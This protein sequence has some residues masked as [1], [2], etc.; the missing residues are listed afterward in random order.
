MVNCPITM[1]NHPFWQ[2][3]QLYNKWAIFNSF[4]YVITRGYPW[5]FSP[6]VPYKA[7]FC[8]DIHLH[9]PYIGLIDGRYLHFR[10]LKFPL[11][12]STICN[13]LGPVRLGV[14]GSLHLFP[15]PEPRQPHL[16]PFLA[17]AGD[18]GRVQDRVR[19]GL[20]VLWVGNGCAVGWN[21]VFW[22]FWCFLFLLF[23]RGFPFFLFDMFCSMLFLS[24]LVILVFDGR[25]GRVSHP[26]LRNGPKWIEID[27]R[28]ARKKYFT[29]TS[30]H[31][32]PSN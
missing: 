12:R 24:C 19:R 2:V 9:W 4:L 18:S 14:A 21:C 15:F 22:W 13:P 20:E 30:H 16:T 3:N 25:F 28:F 17:A 10:I 8:G 26:E 6:L 27:V 29:I 23:F 32:F 31:F 1:E 11:I 5:Y 7:I